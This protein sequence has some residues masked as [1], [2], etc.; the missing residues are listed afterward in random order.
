VGDMAWTLSGKV[1]LVTGGARGIGAGTAAELARRGARLVLADLDP[2][3]MADTARRITPQPLTIELDVTDMVACEAAVQQVLSEHG[4]LDVAWANAGIASFGPLG[5]TA[6]SAWRRTVEVNLLGAYNTL[7]AALPAV[8]EQ[9]GYLAVTASLASFAH[10]P[11]LSAYAA[12]KAGVE[13]MCNSLRTEVAHLGV[14]VATIHPSW[15]DTDMVREGDEAQRSFQRLREAMKEP[16]KRTYPLERA[17][18]D[19]VTGFEARKRRI[20]SPRFAVI[21][22]WLRPLLATTAFE[23]DQRAAAPEITRLF[24]E[25]LAER[26]AEAAS[27]SERVAEQLDVHLPSAIS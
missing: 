11:G 19:I 9:R 7:R 15:I 12:S 1:I 3:P 8:C 21:A 26:G 23:R 24:E 27:T 5:L 10:A 13:A 18:S 16:F 2:G 25:E 14:D 22:H 4:R 20:C 17:V 6:P